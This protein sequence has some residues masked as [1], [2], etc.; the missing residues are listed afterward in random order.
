MPGNFTGSIT[1]GERG[2][3]L[4]HS[5][6]IHRGAVTCHGSGCAIAQ[7]SPQTPPG[8]WYVLGV[9]GWDPLSPSWSQALLLP[10]P[11]ASMRHWRSL[12]QS[13]QPTADTEVW[14]HLHR[15][16]VGKGGVRS[17]LLVQVWEQDHEKI[18]ETEAGN[19]TEETNTSG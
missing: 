5:H 10:P 15:H 6:H 16:G 2:V 17:E 12:N 11:S 7:H 18:R 1:T 4:S 19:S 14:W 13:S 8:I 9:P 3:R